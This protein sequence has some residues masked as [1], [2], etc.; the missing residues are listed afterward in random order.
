[1]LY[2]LSPQEKAEQLIQEVFNS[3]SDSADGEKILM[4][5]LDEILFLNHAPTIA[6][7]K[8]ELNGELIEYTQPYYWMQVKTH[9]KELL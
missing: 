9:I 8:Q 4:M 3:L 5:L 6:Y 1:M 2:D 7:S